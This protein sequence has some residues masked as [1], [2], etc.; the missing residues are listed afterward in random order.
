MTLGKC[1]DRCIVS[2]IVIGYQECLFQTF[3][4][5][6]FQQRMTLGK[7]YESCIVSLVSCGVL[8]VF[9]SDLSLYNILGE[10]DGWEG[11]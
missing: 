7:C 5:I 11:L 10:S 4:Y 6:I 3:S 1:F 9:L 8:G 2:Y